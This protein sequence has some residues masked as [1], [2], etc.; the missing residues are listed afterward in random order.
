M[1]KLIKKVSKLLMCVL[2][3][4]TVFAFTADKVLAASAPSSSTVKRTKV[5]DS[6]I[7]DN[8]GFTAFA[9]EDGTIVYCMDIDKK[10][11]TT[12]MG[13]TYLA[14]GDQ[15]LLYIIKNSYPN[16]TITGVPERDQYIT[17]SAIWWYLD[18]IN[19]VNKLDPAFKTTDK[20]AYPGM[21]NEIIKLV[22]AGKAYKNQTQATPSMTLTTGETNLKLTSDKK[23]YESDYMSAS[24][25]A[26]SSYNVEATGAK[27]I[28][29]I[30]AKGAVQ[31]K[32]NSGEK[33]K[34]KIP[35][36]DITAKTT[37]T[38]KTTAV[39]GN[40]MVATYKPNDSAYQRVVSSKIYT[41]EVNLEKK[42]TLSV[43]PVAQEKHV[44]EF[45]NN[46]YY[47]KNGNV[48][49]KDTYN[50]EC[51]EPEKK[52]CQVDGDKYYGKDGNLVD[53][54]TYDKECGETEEV[55]VPNTGANASMF[56]MGVGLMII[57]SGAG[58]IAYRKR[59]NQ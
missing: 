4:V 57:A 17:Q 14:E 38:V 28:N 37:I 27:N 24:L 40:E 56:V 19:G 15:G 45:T 12:G 3:V 34:V 51:G 52:V 7:G 5:M 39:G 49:D 16:K 43:T 20:E 2:A 25:V 18:D 30:N 10:G 1:E 8:N 13:Y 31:Q 21:R 50:K 47:G 35:A 36:G 29:I 55:I 42:A 11:A 6:Y 44:C 9:T 53:R 22:N 59:F 54:F 33:F 32:Y 23:Y 48:V 58:L 46:T 41:K 26:A